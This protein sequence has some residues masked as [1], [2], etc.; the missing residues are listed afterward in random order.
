MVRNLHDR[1]IIELFFE[2]SEQAIIELSNKYGFICTKVAYNIL[3]NKQDAEECVNDAYLGAWNTI[4]PQNPDSLIG[5]VCR[6]V[7]NIAIK[8]YH[9]NTATK[10]NSVYDVALDELENCIPSI[11]S[12]EDEMT[13]NE[14]SKQINMFLETLDKESRILFVRRYWHSDS[15]DELAK[16]FCT[17]K[18]NV[19]VR[20][21]RIREKLKKYLIRK[22]V[23]L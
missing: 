4:P 22:G 2:R 7:R 5:Y 1:K 11:Y 6:I 18:H 17:S 13:A 15:I 3:N 21:S 12:V 10:R 9:Y 8:K 19:S 14:I 16:L 20:L 23:S